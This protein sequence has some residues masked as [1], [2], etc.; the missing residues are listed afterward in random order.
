LSDLTLIPE[1]VGVGEVA[2]SDH[3]SSV[4]TQAELGRLA[5]E[6]HVGALY[7]QKA[8]TIIFH[9][10][11][12]KGGLQPLRELLEESDL[13]I[14]Q[15]LP[16]HV[17]RTRMLWE[18]ALAFAR[19]GGVVD[20]TA[21]IAPAH[22]FPAALKPADALAEAVD[23]GIPIERVTMSSDANGNMPFYDDQGRL[24]RV[25]VQSVHDLLNELRDL[26]CTH[27]V[28]LEVA[29]Q[30]V[31][32]NVARVFGLR[33]KGRLAVGFDADLAIVSEDV[34]IQTLI[35]RGRVLVTDGVPIVRGFFE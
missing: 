4:P 21:G 14:A 33:S 2:V 35:A 3:R 8:G 24:A 34:R 29:L 26:V 19:Q 13:P 5:A 22:G 20:V 16:T 31:T 32:S 6:A 27:G 30:P 12:G 23:Q 25:V 7:G 1:I 17:N 11:E 28:P 15:M 10:G 18:D 9:V